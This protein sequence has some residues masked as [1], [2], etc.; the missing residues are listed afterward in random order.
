[1]TYNS[2]IMFTIVYSLFDTA[3]CSTHEC[4]KLL[5]NG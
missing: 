4:P 5:Q 1:M 3:C 2:T